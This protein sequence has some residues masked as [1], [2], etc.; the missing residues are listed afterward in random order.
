MTPRINSAGPLE[1]IPRAALFSCTAA[2]PRALNYDLH[3]LPV[4]LV[5]AFIAAALHVYIFVLES[6]T[7]TTPKTWRTFNVP[8][9]EA[10][11]ITRPL[12]YNQG[13]YNL[14]LALGAF[15]GVLLV[16]I[17]AS[18]GSVI[19]GW[20]LLFSSCG[21]MLLAAAVLAQTGGKSIRPTIVQGTT[22]FVAVAFGLLAVAG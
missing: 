9:Q 15:L 5:F 1:V 14:F 8:S 18:A 17:G 22:P 2:G 21:S 19:A 16:G 12:A 3:M 7:W 6:I 13:F 4:A 11:N 10:A 20:A